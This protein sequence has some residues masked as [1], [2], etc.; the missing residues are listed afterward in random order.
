VIHNN[1]AVCQQRK[2]DWW[3]FLS[4]LE[5]KQAYGSNLYQRNQLLMDE[6]AN[7]F[8][9]KYFPPVKLAKFWGN[10]TTFSQFDSKSIYDAWKRYK[11]LIRKVSNHGLPDWLEIQFFYNGLQLK[12]KMMV[13]AAA[14]G[15]L[16]RKDRDEAYELLEEMVS[17]DYHWKLKKR[18]RR[19]LR[20]CMDLM[21]SQQFMSNSHH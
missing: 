9:T 2:W 4:H 7:K 19:R 18:R 6:M 1:I 17:N 21:I 5:T 8:L 3:F 13:D 11:G 16:M 15:A 20:A 12:T 10:I 14:G